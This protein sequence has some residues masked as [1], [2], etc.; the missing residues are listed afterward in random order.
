MRAL[1]PRIVPSRRAASS[2]VWMCS[3][4]WVLDDEIL[5]AIRDPAHGPVEQAREIRNEHFLGIERALDAKTTAD[6]RRNDP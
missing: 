2:R 1:S 5:A 3:R 4:A 6:I